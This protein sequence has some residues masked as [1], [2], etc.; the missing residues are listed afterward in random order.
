MERPYEVDECKIPGHWEADLIKDTKNKSAI[1]TL[2]ERNRWLCILAKLS[3]AKAESV[4]AALT[5]ALCYLP[6]ELI[7]KLTYDRG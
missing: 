7:K 1:A 4:C 5:E 2:V 3:E 6:A